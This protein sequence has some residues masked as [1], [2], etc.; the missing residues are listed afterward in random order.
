M[1]VRSFSCK[2]AQY[3]TS[4]CIQQDY[5]VGDAFWGAIPMDTVVFDI[6][7]VTETH[8]TEYVELTDVG[9]FFQL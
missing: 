3:S 9:E 7:I 2:T 8:Q 4:N 5:S 6:A 1:L